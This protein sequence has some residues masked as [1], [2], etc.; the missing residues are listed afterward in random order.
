[1]VQWCVRF[2][3][4]RAEIFWPSPL[5]LLPGS[6][7]GWSSVLRW[8]TRGW[9]RETAYIYQHCWRDMEKNAKTLFGVFLKAGCMCVYIYENNTSTLTNPKFPQEHMD[10]MDIYDHANNMNNTNYIVSVNFRILGPAMANKNGQTSWPKTTNAYIWSSMRRPPKELV[11]LEYWPDASFN[12]WYPLKM[13]F[14]DV[15]RD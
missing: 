6:E 4:Q 7:T 9:P 3:V 15:L 5:L 8:N 2:W 13:K 12:G 10:I 1:M 11:R 14:E